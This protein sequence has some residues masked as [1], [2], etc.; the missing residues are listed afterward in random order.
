LLHP[1]LMGP[2]RALPPRGSH[3]RPGNQAPLTAVR[4]TGGLYPLTPPLPRSLN[5]CCSAIELWQPPTRSLTAHPTR[6][7]MYLQL[8]KSTVSSVTAFAPRGARL[9]AQEEGVDPRFHV[10]KVLRD[11]QAWILRLV[12]ETQL[13]LGGYLLYWR[14]WHRGVSG[15]SGVPSLAYGGLL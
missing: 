10:I 15:I 1:H 7:T 9:G 4:I 12:L 2:G 3:L 5:T 14:C 8:F 11:P 13:S 6:Y